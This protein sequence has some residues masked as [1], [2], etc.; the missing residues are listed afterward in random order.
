MSELNTQIAGIGALLS[1]ELAID[2]E[3]GLSQLSAFALEMAM[4]KA[5][6]PYT[7]LG[8]SERRH[9]QMPVLYSEDGNMLRQAVEG[10]QMYH[11]SDTPEN[12][13]A[14]IPLNGVMRSTSA[15]ST[16]GTDAIERDLRAAYNN[17]NIAAIVMDINSGG[18][19]AVAGQRLASIVSTRNKP[20]ISLGHFVGSAAYMVASA[21]DEVLAGS[22][23]ARFGSIG[24]LY[25]IDRRLLTEYAENV[26]EVYAEQSTQ[27]NAAHRAAVTGDFSLLKKEAT[28][29]AQS[30]IDLVQSYRG[31]SETNAEKAFTG[32]MF[33]AREAKR[34]G[35]IDISNGNL[36]TALSRAT[37]WAKRGKKD[38]K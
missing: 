27:K 29:S 6:V 14:L 30:F 38:K 17:R 31:I 8:I 18:G 13:I 37:T 33:D 16:R 10:W 11:E 36:N 22:P 20:V 15:A 24:A 25:Q 26:I 7:E 35:L 34:M 19:E 12:S 2:Q 23:G 21:S 1:G 3:W 5:G 28:K 9:S 32:A 4:A